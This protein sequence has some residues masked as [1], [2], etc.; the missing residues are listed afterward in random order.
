MKKV[1]YF[2]LLL[3]ICNDVVAQ[4][5]NT[6][7]MVKYWNYRYDLIGDDIDPSYAKWEPGFLDLTDAQGGCIPAN[8]QRWNTDNST[9]RDPIYSPSLFYDNNKPGACANQGVYETHFIRPRIL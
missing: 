6:Y 9:S 3:V 2:L 7:N 8:V 1:N 5:S 4:I